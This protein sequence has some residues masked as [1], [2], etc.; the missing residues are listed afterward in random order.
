MKTYGEVEVYLH[1]FW[2]PPWISPIAM[3][4]G[5][6]PLSLDAERRQIPSL[7]SSGY[8]LGHPTELAAILVEL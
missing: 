1:H 7:F 5:L 2:P 6:R 3:E 8:E 4:N